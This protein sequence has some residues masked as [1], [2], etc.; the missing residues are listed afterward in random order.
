MLFPERTPSDFA[1]P[2]SELLLLL[3]VEADLAELARLRCAIRRSVLSWGRDGREV[4]RS[5]CLSAQQE[6]LVSIS[7]GNLM[8]AAHT[9]RRL[10]AE[11]SLLHCPGIADEA[12][13]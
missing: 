12:P 9:G 1:S 13:C 5:T 8:T 7:L 2:S 3:V 6:G 4:A 10:Q 11:T